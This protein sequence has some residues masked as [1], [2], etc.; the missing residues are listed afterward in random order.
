MCV[1]QQFVKV[2]NMLDEVIKMDEA[3]SLDI[4]T[5]TTRP[6]RQQQ[7]QQQH[8]PHHHVILCYL[9]PYVISDGASG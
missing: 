4:G 3:N 6:R 8:H 5:T 9:C 1:W 2:A 7:Q